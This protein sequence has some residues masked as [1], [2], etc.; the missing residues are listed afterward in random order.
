MAAATAVILAV[1]AVIAVRAVQETTSTVVQQ[2]VQVATALAGRLAATLGGYRHELEDLGWELSQETD[3]ERRAA[4]LE[5]SAWSRRFAGLAIVR[6]D[7]RVIWAQPAMWFGSMSPDLAAAIADATAGG[8]APLPPIAVAPAVHLTALTV[9][10]PDGDVLVGAV[11]LERLALA[12]TFDDGNGR[13][14]D[15]EIMDPG[16]TVRAAAVL[17]DVGRPSEHLAILAP[18]VR[19]GQTAVAFHNV[20]GHPHYVA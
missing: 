4:V 12:G 3:P 13:P 14:V 10:L 18:L 19:P 17:A 1:F 9:P 6:A 7:G 20:P 16:G 11:D 5:D 2:R 15:F 8:A